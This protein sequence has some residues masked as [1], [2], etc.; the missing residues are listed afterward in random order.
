MICAPKSPF[1][2]TARPDATLAGYSAGRIAAESGGLPDLLVRFVVAHRRHVQSLFVPIEY[3]LES[4]DMAAIGHAGTWSVFE[5]AVPNRQA[6][7]RTTPRHK[8][9][10]D[11]ISAAR[12]AASYIG[13]ANCEAHVIGICQTTELGTKPVNRV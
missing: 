9:V 13:R 10:S 8:D 4:A 6:A 11:D 2:L 1:F 3:Q 7:G 5:R 12:E